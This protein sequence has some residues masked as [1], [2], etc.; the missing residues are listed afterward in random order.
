L[1]QKSFQKTNN[2]FG[3]LILSVFSQKMRGKPKKEASILGV[4]CAKTF[5]KG[6]NFI[7]V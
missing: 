5:S 7:I 4:F 6:F 1:A 2:G 3:A